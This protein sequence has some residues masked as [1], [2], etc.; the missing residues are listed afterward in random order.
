MR[1]QVKTVLT[2]PNFSSFG[3]RRANSRTWRVPSTLVERLSSIPK[4][5]R[6]SAAQCRMAVISRGSSLKFERSPRTT[7]ASPKMA[8]R[9]VRHVTRR[10]CASARWRNSEPTSPVAPVRNKWDIQVNG[11]AAR[12]DSLGR[13]SCRPAAFQ[14]IQ[15]PGK[16]AAATIGRPH[17]NPSYNGW[18]VYPPSRQTSCVFPPKISGNV[19]D[20]LRSR[21]VNFQ[22]TASPRLKASWISAP[23]REPASGVQIPGRTHPLA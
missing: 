11:L 5:K 13:Q 17:I 21:G 10:S 3:Q 18:N 1:P 22:A 2:Y 4:L 7:T 12:D 8:A 9:R 20:N 6:V 14:R 16:E 23:D 15:P 19:M